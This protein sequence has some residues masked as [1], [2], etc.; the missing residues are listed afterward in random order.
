[1]ETPNNNN[2]TQKSQFVK[3]NVGGARYITTRS[4]LSGCGENFFTQ[5][6]EHNDSGKIMYEID[7]EGYIL[8]DRNGNLFEYVLDYLRNGTLIC[9]GKM[10]LRKRV[11]RELEFYGIGNLQIFGKHIE[12]IRKELDKSATVIEKSI[13]NAARKGKIVWKL[14]HSRLVQDTNLLRHKGTHLEHLGH[15]VTPERKVI[16]IDIEE[17]EVSVCILYEEFERRWGLEGLDEDDS[18]SFD[19]KSFIYG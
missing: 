5:M 7:E 12:K 16:D 11:K 6:L 19:L 15:L 17:L 1:M 2:A 8:I 4:T 9:T 3:L 13:Q 10:E 18:I 14:K